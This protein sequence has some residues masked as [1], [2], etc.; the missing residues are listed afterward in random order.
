[1][2][3]SA[4]I[5]QNQASRREEHA[6]R[7]QDVFVP[8]DVPQAWRFRHYRDYRYR[9]RTDLVGSVEERDSGGVLREVERMRSVT[10]GLT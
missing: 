9:T 7:A 3:R 8:A 6:V 4:R 5:L 2:T 10:L 1:M